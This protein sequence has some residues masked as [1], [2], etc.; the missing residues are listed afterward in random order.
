MFYPDTTIDELMPDAL[1]HTLDPANQAPFINHIGYFTKSRPKIVSTE[2]EKSKT[3]ITG[4]SDKQLKTN[5]VWEVYQVAH[6]TLPES[7]LCHPSIGYATRYGNVMLNGLDNSIDYV[8]TNN[9]SW[10]P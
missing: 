3:F 2:N 8:P 10:R 9:G 1:V 7:V 6:G 4:N 5:Q